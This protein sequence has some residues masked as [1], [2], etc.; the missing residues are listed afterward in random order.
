MSMLAT[1][2][3][4]DEYWDNYSAGN[5]VGFF[6]FAASGNRLWENTAERNVRGFVVNETTD[7]TLVENVADRNTEMGFVLFSFS[8][9]N[10]LRENIARHNGDGFQFIVESNNN[11]V[12]E[13]IARNNKGWNAIQDDTSIDFFCEND[14]KKTEGF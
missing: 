4:G 7:S 2:G 9:R 13:N 8:E 3:V 5:Y 11:T 1:R 10:E 12:R 14:F 6:I